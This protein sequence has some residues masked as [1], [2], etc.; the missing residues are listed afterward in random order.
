V[1]PAV[2]VTI[3]PDGLV[4]SAMTTS[5]SASCGALLA[6]RLTIDSEAGPICRLVPPTS[7][8]YRVSE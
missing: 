2:N 4:A 3:A 6:G 8:A 1:P 7:C 5:G